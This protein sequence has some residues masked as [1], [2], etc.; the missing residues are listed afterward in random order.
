[1]DELEHVFGHALPFPAQHAL[2]QTIAGPATTK[3]RAELM[4]VWAG[5]SASL[6]HHAK[7]DE[8]M[9]SLIAQIDAWHG[10]V[11]KRYLFS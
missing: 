4:T 11:A 1:M 7:A 6:C 5:Q 2:T 3:G 10:A 8:F 9:T